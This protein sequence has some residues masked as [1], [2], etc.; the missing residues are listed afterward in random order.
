VD[1]MGDRGKLSRTKYTQKYN[2]PLVGKNGK[3]ETIW[4]GVGVDEKIILK[5]KG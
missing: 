5:W 3:E 4:E 1:E 2:K